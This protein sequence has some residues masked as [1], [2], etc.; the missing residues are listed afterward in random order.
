MLK[1][2]STNLLDKNRAVGNNLHAVLAAATSVKRNEYTI[3]FSKEV[4]N[5]LKGV[6]ACKRTEVN[7]L[8]SALKCFQPE[9]SFDLR[10][11]TLNEPNNP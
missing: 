8:T 4:Y 7:K 1:Q 9:S 6:L 5:H 3:L 2:I 10:T 11:P